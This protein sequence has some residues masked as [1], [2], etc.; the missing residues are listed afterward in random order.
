L[1]FKVDKIMRTE[2]L[3][4]KQETTRSIKNGVLSMPMN[5]RMSQLR[6]N[7][8]KSSDF[9]LRGTSTLS[10]NYQLTDTLT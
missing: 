10:H 4:W 9:M 1:Q 8:T 6:D 3:S 7:L 2:T 5:M